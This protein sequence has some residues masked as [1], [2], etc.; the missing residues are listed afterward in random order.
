MLIIVRPEFINV[1]GKGTR[2]VVHLMITCLDKVVCNSWRAW[3]G[4]ILSFIISYF[5]NISYRDWEVEVNTCVLCLNFLY[6]VLLNPQRDPPLEN[7]L[8]KG[9]MTVYVR[10]RALGKRFRA[11]PL[12]GEALG[13]SPLCTPYVFTVCTGTIVITTL[14]IIC[15]HSVHRHDC[16]HLFAHYMFSQCAQ[17]R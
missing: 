12:S 7:Q 15:F 3:T 1:L 14:H 11:H 6:V 2:G 8:P 5:C 9:L 10:V 16:C 13:G 17:A 4:V